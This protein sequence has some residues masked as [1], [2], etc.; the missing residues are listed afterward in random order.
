[1][2]TNERATRQPDNAINTKILLL[3]W[4]SKLIELQ[5]H[6]SSLSEYSLCLK[7]LF[8]AINQALGAQ[9]LQEYLRY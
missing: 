4:L 3:T 7:R 8:T 2:R 9:S 1:M 6:Q 5:L